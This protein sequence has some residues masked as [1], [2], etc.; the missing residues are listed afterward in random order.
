MRIRIWAESKEKFWKS[1]YRAI[2]P[3][4]PL[5]HLG[6]ATTTSPD[7]WQGKGFR[8][9]HTKHTRGQGFAL[10]L[11]MEG[12]S[13]SLVPFPALAPEL[14]Q[15]GI[16]SLGDWRVLLQRNWMATG[17]IPTDKNNSGYSIHRL[18]LITLHCSPLC[19]KL[20]QNLVA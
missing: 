5:L 18:L 3:T 19:N 1:T 9:R 4:R 7:R 14:R 16:Y 15:P 11:K 12:I 2:S 6:V 13:E 20:L 17:K 8:I 10:G